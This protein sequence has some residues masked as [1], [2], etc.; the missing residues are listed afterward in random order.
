M[1][2]RAGVDQNGGVELDGE[3]TGRSTEHWFVLGVALL[4]PLVM[5]AMGLY[6]EPDARG[7]GTHEQLGLRPCTTMDLWG[8]PCP[9]CGVTTSVTMAVQG[10]PWD[11][12][13][14]QPFGFGIA[15]GAVLFVLWA[16]WGQ[17]TGRDLYRRLMGLRLGRW[18]AALVAFVLASWIYK[19]AIT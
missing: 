16:L 19:L 1:F 18:G 7:I 2:R 4:V 15:V 13:V 12:F 9:G 3:E 10:R 14:T 11:S 8:F 17:V 6:F 5:V